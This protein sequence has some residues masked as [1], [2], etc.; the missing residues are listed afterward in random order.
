MK[1]IVNYPLTEAKT[2]KKFDVL[3]EVT[4]LE[5]ST[6]KIKVAVIDFHTDNAIGSDPKNRVEIIKHL[7][8]KWI[9]KSIAEPII[10]NVKLR[11]LKLN[12]LG[13]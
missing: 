2:K 6:N 1:A 3:Y 11:D 8:N 4:I 5:T 7:D 12:E 13:I 9:S 10:D